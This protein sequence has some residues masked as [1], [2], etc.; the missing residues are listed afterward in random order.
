M[1]ATGSPGAAAPAAVSRGEGPPSGAWL[2]AAAIAAASL[3]LAADAGAGILRVRATVEPSIVARGIPAVVTVTVECDGLVGP[4]IDA[5]RPVG[6]SLERVG[7]SQNIMLAAGSVVRTDVAL[8]RVTGSLPGKYTIPPFRIELEGRKVESNP[9][10]LE[11]TASP[12]V[13]PAPSEGGGESEIF[14]RL[15]V[16]RK[17][18]FWNEQIVARAQIFS[19]V[20]LED[21]PAWEAPEATGFWAEPLGAPRHDRVT[22]EGKSYERYERV[23][24]YFPTRPG[25]LTLGPARARIRVVQQGLPAFDPMGGIFPSPSAAIME[26]PIEAAP[27]TIA[28]DP[29]PGGAPPEFTGAV[30]QLTLGVRVDRA[31]VRVGEPVAVAT[32]I[33]GDGNLA[34]AFDPPIVA[35]PAA[36]SYPTQSR[37]ELDR[38]AD[39]LRGTRRREIAFIPDH[40]GSLLVLPIAFAWFDPEEGRYRVERSDSIVVRVERAAGSGDSA[41][42]AG[43]AETAIRIPASPRRAGGAGSRDGAVG[44]LGMWPTG[45]PLT[46]S[47]LS[48]GVYAAL[49]IYA[50]RRRR[51]ASDPRL[52]RRAFAEEA[53]RRAQGAATRFQAA[54]ASRAARVRA[55][56]E[57][58][59]A[60][61]DAAGIRFGIDPEGRS[62]RDLLERLRAAG[63]SHDEFARLT[64]LLERLEA[65][66]FAPEPVARHGQTGGAGVG[67]SALEEAAALAAEWR[68]GT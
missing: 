3:G 59:A 6:L 31:S 5:P 54:G 32:S 62:R 64:S 66:A 18:V 11:I 21:M 68:Q 57:A 23:V 38:S 41:E 28:V 36:A 63:V 53:K 56:E 27:L 49:S 1:G 24:A 16:D 30:G 26:V 17:R 25:R 4:S 9:L 48:F 29:L 37:A 34:S 51:A 22:V 14:A 13:G 7:T 39:R 50:G 33:R 61:R 15:V 12:P 55:A 45:L 35:I 47:A 2:L 19:R 46:A 40:P 60:L 67:G 52:V 58:E 8:F 42:A 10:S 44:S 43:L 20:P 65:T